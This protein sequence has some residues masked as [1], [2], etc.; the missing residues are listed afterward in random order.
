MEDLTLNK[1]QEV[2]RKVFAQP[3]LIIDRRTTADNVFMW[4]SLTHLELI[5]E[6]EI[7]FGIEF[8]FDEVVSFSNVGQLLDCILRKQNKG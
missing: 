8:S 5:A 4:D 6:V 7:A 3:G 2:L 1:L